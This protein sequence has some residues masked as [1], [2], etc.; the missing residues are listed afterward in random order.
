MLRL[1]FYIEEDDPIYLQIQVL[2]VVALVIVHNN[3]KKKPIEISYLRNI[4]MGDDY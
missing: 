1:C 3:I 4:T 2:I